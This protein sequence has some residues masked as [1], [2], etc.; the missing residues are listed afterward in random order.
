MTRLA[1]GEW[2]LRIDDL[3]SPRIRAGAETT[4]LKDLAW[5]GLDWDGLVV[6]QS[7]RRGI[8]ASVLSWLR[9]AGK[10][11]PCRCSR[12]FLADISA[13]HGLGSVYPGFCRHRPQSWGW[14]DGRLP[15]W[16][17][18]V[19][20]VEFQWVERFGS[21]GRLQGSS[22]VGDV[23][24]RRADGLVAY[25]LATAVDELLL[26]ISDVVRGLDLWSSTA[27]QLAVFE[28]MGGPPPRYGHIP[29]WREADGRRLSKRSAAEGLVAYQ[30]KG[31][32][33]AAVV[34]T[35]ASSL[36]L[37]PEGSQLSASELLASINYRDLDRSLQ[38]APEDPFAT[39]LQ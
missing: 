8:Y 30:Q 24:L 14:S 16:R 9:L 35:L 27:S 23:V 21:P 19:P 26:G 12:R 1:G 29:L 33:A 17:M 34:G 39:Q 28:A 13:P 7:Q 22:Q 15:S 32:D 31:M 38:L 25:H 11:Y 20:D 2:I 36:G 3:D 5:L 4:I 6:R 37:V 18:R 10:L